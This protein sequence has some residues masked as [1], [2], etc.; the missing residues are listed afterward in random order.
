[1]RVQDY[2]DFRGGIP[3]M[4]S[5]GIRFT[6]PRRLPGGVKGSGLGFRVSGFGFRVSGFGFR[7]QGLGFGFRVWSLGFRI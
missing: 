3:G 5:R 4:D 2:R 7:V 6:P 1:L